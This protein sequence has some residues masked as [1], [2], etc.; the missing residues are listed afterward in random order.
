MYWHYAN[1]SGI[2]QLMLQ[3]S[4]AMIATGAS[5]AKTPFDSIS[6][7]HQLTLRILIATIAT[8]ALAANM[9]FNNTSQIPKLTVDSRWKASVTLF[10][11]RSLTNRSLT[12]GAPRQAVD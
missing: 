11:V 4:V 12:K 6:A 3:A 7:T 9:P 8:G 5:A 1:T 10:A 2:R